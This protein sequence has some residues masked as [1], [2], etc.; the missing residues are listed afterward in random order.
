MQSGRKPDLRAGSRFRRGRCCGQATRWSSR[1]GGSTRGPRHPKRCAKRPALRLSRRLERSRGRRTWRW[2]YA[3][4]RFDFSGAPLVLGERGG[5][6][7]CSSLVWLRGGSGRCRRLRCRRVGRVTLGDAALD[8]GN[9]SDKFS[10]KT[11]VDDPL[12]GLAGHDA[13]PLTSRKVYRGIPADQ[14]RKTSQAG[15]RRF[16]SGR[17]L[18]LKG[19][20]VTVT[21]SEFQPRTGM[22]T[23][24]NSIDFLNFSGD[25][26]GQ[27]APLVRLE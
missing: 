25:H 11:S 1:R 19:L 9:G 10:D 5:Q 12:P 26:G 22:C 20:R 7:S 8:A 6:R 3:P 4:S 23:A 13:R 18:Q 14:P 2:R 15:R 17:P 27:A 24:L 16:E 21:P